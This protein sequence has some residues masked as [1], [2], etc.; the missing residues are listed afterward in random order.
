MHTARLDKRGGV[1]Q[2]EAR[3]LSMNEHEL[4]RG[5]RT[6]PEYKMSGAHL[7]LKVETITHSLPWI[8]GCLPNSSVIFISSQTVVS[9]I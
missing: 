5:R 2:T 4:C 8:T 7:I 3:C 1:P 9:A 6:L